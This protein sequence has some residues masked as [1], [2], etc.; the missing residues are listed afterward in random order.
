VF[1]CDEGENCEAE[2]EGEEEKT[3]LLM[4]CVEGVVEDEE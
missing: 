1:G 3:M 2:E 4:G